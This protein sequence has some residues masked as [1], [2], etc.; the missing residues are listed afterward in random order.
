MQCELNEIVVSWLPDAISM[1]ATT[2]QLSLV[3]GGTDDQRSRLLKLFMGFEP[4]S[5]GFVC[6]DGEPLT[7][8]NASELRRL[9]AFAPRHLPVIGETDPCYPPSVQDIFSLHANH[10][11]PVSNGLLAETMRSLTPSHDTS[12][13]LQW[14]AVALLLGR[15][16]L[17]ADHPPR[18]TAASLAAI[19]RQGTAVIVASDDQAFADAADNIT[20]LNSEKSF[21]R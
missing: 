19:A 15:P 7:P 11:R 5:S 17:L 20:M 3:S 1:I 16:V 9:M 2:G 8:D 6:V 13:Q 10:N 12:E 4:L 18:E 14:L 21:I